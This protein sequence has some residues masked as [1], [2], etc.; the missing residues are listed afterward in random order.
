VNVDIFIKGC[1]LKNKQ[2]TT[3]LEKEQ[4]KRKEN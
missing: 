4:K 2:K 1:K 3:K